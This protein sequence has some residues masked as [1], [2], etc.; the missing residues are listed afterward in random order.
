MI[1]EMPCKQNANYVAWK[2]RFERHFLFLNNEDTIL[3]GHSQGA[4]FLTKRLSENQFPKKVKQLHLVSSVFD[5]NNLDE[6]TIG[7][8]AFDPKNLGNITNQCEKIILYHSKDDDIVPFR[9]SEELK[10]HLPKATF[11]IFEDKGHFRQEEFP[12]LLENIKNK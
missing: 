6:E 4:V 5:D 3:I 9:H 1:P 8:F 10:K 2:I 12:K 7:N 11:F